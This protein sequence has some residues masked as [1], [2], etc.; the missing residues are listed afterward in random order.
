MS[1]RIT[2]QR[3]NVLGQVNQDTYFG[4]EFTFHH[5]HV[6]RVIT[7]PVDLTFLGY[8]TNNMP[9]DVSQCILIS[10]TFGGNLGFNL[11][12]NYL[13]GKILA[14]PLLRGFSDSI[15]RGDS[16]IYTN[17]GNLF[18]YLGPIN[19][20]NNPNKTPDHLYDPGLNPT[21]V[22]Q[23]IRKDDKDGY[24][25]NF[26]GKLISKV[27]KDKNKSLDNPY[28]IGIGEDGSDADVESTVTDMQFEGR[29]GNSIQIGTRFMNPYI[30]I[31]NNILGTNNGSGFG[32]LSFGRIKDYYPGFNKLSFDKIA[33]ENE[34]NKIIGYGN[35]STGTFPENKF[36]YEFAKPQPKSELQTEFDQVIMFSD[37]ITFD[38]QNN[39]FT[40]S[41]KRNINFGAG[42]N[43]TLTNKGFTVF[44]TKNIYIGRKSKNKDQPMVL[45]DELRDLLY[46]IM[47]ILQ[48][49]RALVQGV[50]IPF[51]DKNSQPMFKKIKELIDELE[52]RKSDDNGLPLPE[53]NKG[54]ITNFLSQH[55]FIE[56]NRS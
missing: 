13:K 34:S 54:K 55:H 47:N 26:I 16:V 27:I 1:N 48:E 35:D 39:D 18:F 46:R 50:P 12:S 24:N 45:G 29:H 3:T 30:T 32:L 9:S 14:Q 33:D 19:T 17:L 49:S 4:P 43:F 51:V 37:R 20:T 53:N 31:K 7:D 41:A 44:E 8:S 2:P 21:R 52:P 40:V 10:S 6:E 42:K 56:T 28:N 11:P 23:D 25:I 15:T 22:I 36:N 5:G 38:A